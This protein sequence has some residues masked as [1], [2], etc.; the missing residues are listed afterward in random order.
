MYTGRV[1]EGTLYTAVAGSGFPRP[2]G[3]GGVTPEMGAQTC[4]LAKYF[5]ENCF[6]NERN[7]TERGS[8]W[9]C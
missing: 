2:F 4:Y 9:I 3:G 5:D 6:E 8:S 1:F 7:L